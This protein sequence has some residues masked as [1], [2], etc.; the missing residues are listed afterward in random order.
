MKGLLLSQSCDPKPSPLARRP[1]Q[2]FFFSELFADHKMNGAT[3]ALD[4]PIMAAALKDP[5]HTVPTV[6]RP[7]LSHH[8]Q[9]RLRR[10]NELT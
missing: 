6:L 9:P 5:N 2:E 1:G 10:R 3:E 8:R 7:E 4:G